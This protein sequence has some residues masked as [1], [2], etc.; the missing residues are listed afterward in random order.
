[1]FYVFLYQV[2]WSPL[3]IAS[4]RNSVQVAHILIHAGAKIDI[5]EEVL[6]HSI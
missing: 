1:M 5:P 4:R 3:H 2:G 6:M